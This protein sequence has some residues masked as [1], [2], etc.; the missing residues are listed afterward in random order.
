MNR[1][2]R[3]QKL[4]RWVAT[5][6]VTAA[7]LTGCANMAFFHG[8]SHRAASRIVTAYQVDALMAR[9]APAISTALE[10][11]LPAA[12][13]EPRQ[14]RL[15]R[16]IKQKFKGGSL[17]QDL[18]ERLV[19]RARESGNTGKLKHA[20]AQLKK[21]LARH[22]L[23]SQQRPETDEAR[24]RYKAERLDSQRRQKIQG[25]VQAMALVKR[26]NRFNNE[27][28][29][30]VIAARNA[31]V[32]ADARIDTV[33]GE[34]MLKQTKAGLKTRL[35]RRIPPM[36]AYA[37]RQVGS[38]K[39][40]RYLDLQQSPALTWVNQI[41]PEVLAATIEAHRKRLVHQLKR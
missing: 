1:A 35:T 25:L 33:R 10:R 39:L 11:N 36:M 27:L 16:R 8:A 20:A 32:A 37:Y 34:R 14:R 12:V 18:V 6:C 31:V 15:E 30:T 17:T 22:M 24:Q 19:R 3:W 13:A 21:P 9:A 28:L 4:C 7:L 2:G 26:Q 41:L 5:V 23:Q 40:S 38:E 29:H